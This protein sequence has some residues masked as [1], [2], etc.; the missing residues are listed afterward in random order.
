MS[1]RDDNDTNELPSGRGDLALLLK[2]LRLTKIIRDNDLEWC[3]ESK[4][5]LSEEWM[6]RDLGDTPWLVSRADPNVV[7]SIVVKEG[8]ADCGD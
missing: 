5:W 1:N 7:K 3:D 4:T 6:L 2:M 8:S